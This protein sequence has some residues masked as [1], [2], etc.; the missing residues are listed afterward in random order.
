MIRILMQTGALEWSLPQRVSHRAGAV[1]RV[2]FR[3]TTPTAAPRPYQIYL[4]L[5]DPATGAVIAGTTGPISID[6]VNAFEVEGEGEMTLTAHLRIDYS[7][8]LLQA[9]LYDVQSGEMA[10]GLQSYLE[11]P[12][13]LPEQI[14]GITGFISSV[15]VLGMVTGTVSGIV[16]SGR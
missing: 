4:A 6:G 10:V 1:L 11:Q 5:F 2:I 12:P 16:K 9:A 8:S 13:G 7:N 14:S 15:M 3:I